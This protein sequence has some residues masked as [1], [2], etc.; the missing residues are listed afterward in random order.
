MSSACRSNAR[1]VKIAAGGVFAV[2]VST[3]TIAGDG[4]EFHSF[5]L[6]PPESPNNNAP[7]PARIEL[8][9]R[10][11][12]EARLSRSGKLSC[13]S[14]HKP[15]HAYSDPAPFSRPDGAPAH[16]R[17]AS[18]VLNT[19]YRR[20]V[21][22]EGQASSLE[23]QVELS[24]G[25]YGDLG[26][27]LADALARISSDPIYVRSCAEAYGTAMD[28]DC[29]LRAIAAFER[30]L[31][32]AG[33]RFDRYLF[34]QDKSALTS[35]EHLGWELFSGR[36]ACIDCHDVFHAEVNPLGGAYATFSDERFHN[37]GVGYRNGVMS[38]TGRYVT[39]RAPEDFGAFKTPM[40]R[41]VGRTAP[42]MHDGSL[43]TLEDVVDFYNRGGN[44]NPGK[45][46]GVKP[47]YLSDEEK[48]ALTA[49]LR[50]L[51]SEFT[52]HHQ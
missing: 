26:L 23:K 19:A 13:A 44:D 35:Q 49:F 2:V 42:Y 40:L 31:V 47:L 46:S 30:S 4:P 33:S 12:F 17:N 45:S 3:A 20:S 38:D 27:N 1:W 48:A 6:Y 24:F 32:S 16:L 25:P 50:A 37:L 43:A 36:A 51:D 9:R 52:I 14:C 29:L 10:L 21:G 11:F 5:G 15:E 18:S 8:G 41:N 28:Q 39:T 34:Q 22:W 7:S